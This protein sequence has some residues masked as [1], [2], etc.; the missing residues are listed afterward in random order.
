[1]HLFQTTD[2]ELLIQNTNAPNYS[3]DI[4]VR[5]VLNIMKKPIFCFLFL[6]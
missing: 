3:H 5:I 4:V 2:G 6:S 1:M